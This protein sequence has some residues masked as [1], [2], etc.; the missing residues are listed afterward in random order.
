M[1]TV[2][3]LGLLLRKAWQQVTFESHG[4]FG[5]GVFLL[6]P[7]P[8]RV[9]GPRTRRRL[10]T[11]LL[12]S[13]L[14]LFCLT[15]GRLGGGALV[16]SVKGGGGQIS[17]TTRSAPPPGPGRHPRRCSSRNGGEGRS[18]F[19][20]S[21]FQDRA[22]VALVTMAAAPRS[23]WRLADRVEGKRSSKKRGEGAT[24]LRALW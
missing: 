7:P 17:P 13:L 22:R 14:G 24:P 1:V 21:Y 3:I 6:P 8:K 2:Q 11:A 20:S 5:V 12:R 9:L 16:P 4:G 19:S 10:L 15:G 18:A 23:R